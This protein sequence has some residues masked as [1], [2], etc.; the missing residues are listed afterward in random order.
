V[1]RS[2]GVFTLATAKQKDDAEPDPI[3]FQLRTYEVGVDDDGSPITSCVLVPDVPDTVDTGDTP[4]ESPESPSELKASFMDVLAEVFN[5]G[6]K[7]GTKA[8]IKSVVVAERGL[9]GRSTFYKL[10]NEL[11]GEGH[12]VQGKKS[13][14]FY[15]DGEAPGAN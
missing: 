8:E 11:L 1:T 15:E 2:R 3:Q 4:A 7:G 14:W 9:M 6:T 10:W 5:S 12:L 13:V